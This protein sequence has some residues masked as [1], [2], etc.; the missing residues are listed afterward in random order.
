MQAKDAEAERAAVE[1]RAKEQEQ[2]ARHDAELAAAAA[3]AEHEAQLAAV[4][5][6]VRRRPKKFAPTHSPSRCVRS[7][8]P[9]AE[10]VVLFCGRA[11]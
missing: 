2:A 10:R 1:Q 11:G 3:K 5:A 9:T 8:R 4:K 6:Q 7:P